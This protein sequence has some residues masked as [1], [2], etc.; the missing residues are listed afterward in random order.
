[1]APCYSLHYCSR[2]DSRWFSVCVNEPS[3][4]LASQSLTSLPLVVSSSSLPQPGKL[5]ARPCQYHLQITSIISVE[6]IPFSDHTSCHSFYISIP[7]ILPAHQDHWSYH[8]STN[9][10]FPY[11]LAWLFSGLNCVVIID[12]HCFANPLRSLAPL[13][14]YLYLS[15]KIPTFV[16]SKFLPLH[17]APR[18]WNLC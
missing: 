16:K 6:N 9:S 8:L 10:P 15:G 11:A 12:N 7:T 5:S 1:M 17:I 18:Q 14:I 4:T 13:P 3:N 2:H